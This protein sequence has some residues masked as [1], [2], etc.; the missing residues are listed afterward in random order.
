[1]SNF[2]NRFSMPVALAGVSV[3]LAG[4]AVDAILHRLNPQLAL[5]EGIFALNNPGHLMLALGIGLN[6]MGGIMC[7][8][9][10]ATQPARTAVAR[11]GLGALA[12]LL[13]AGATASLALAVWS[14]TGA[15]HTH[16]G[17]AADDHPADYQTLLEQASPDDMLSADVFLTQ[18]KLDAARFDDIAVAEAEGYRQTTPFRFG[19]T[20][21]AHFANRNYNRDGNILDTE[22]PETLVYYKTSDGSLVL[23]GVMFTAPADQ[24]PDIAGELTQWHSHAQLCAGVGGMAPP[25]GQGKCPDGSQLV[26]GGKMEMLHVWFF[27]NPDG[28]YASSLSRASIQALQQTLGE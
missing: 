28:P 9:G 25:D 18:A 6:V 22:H 20:G 3:T 21:P 15:S 24:A 11:L 17:M 16:A 23:L 5:T 2:L 26:V 4:L 12:A 8:V 13:L 10:H 19:D 14:E 7:L 1:M 27:D